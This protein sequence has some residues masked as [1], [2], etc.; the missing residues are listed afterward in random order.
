MAD[1]DIR[2]I[3]MTLL[4]VFLAVMRR[5]KLT[6]AAEELGLTQST[7]SHAL[8][9]LRQAFADDLFLRRTY[10]VEPTNRSLELEPQIRQIVEM[11]QVA[12]DGGGPFSSVEAS[13][14]IRISMPDHY[15]ALMSA[16][17]LRVISMEAPQLQ[18]SI[19]P[20]VRRAAIEALSSNDVDIALGYFWNLPGSFREKSLFKDDHRVV[21]RIGHPL[22]GDELD[23]ET[24]LR[25]EH[26]LVSLGGDL[27]GVVDK[28][29][30]KLGRKRRLVAGLP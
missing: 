7:I 25:V 9:R 27:E 18:I 30:A 3:D 21:A 16:P 2:R 6:A 5:R 15:C 23:L 12:L 28:A 20:L 13:G 26:A 24:Y 8:A 14:I 11:L 17:L 10:G 19:R 22:I 29:L 1:I 4:L